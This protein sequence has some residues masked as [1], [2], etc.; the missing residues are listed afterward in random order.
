MP[1]AGFETEIPAVQKYTILL[2]EKISL[3]I[4]TEFPL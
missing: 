1:S 2:P 3:D 4:W